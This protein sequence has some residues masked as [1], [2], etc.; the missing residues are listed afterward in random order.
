MARVVFFS[1]D[2]QRYT[3]G[4]KEAD[5]SAR[6]YRDLVAELCR[7]FPGLSEELVRKYALAIDGAII[8]TPLL[9]TIKEDSE[10]VFIP[11]IAGG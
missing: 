11:R 4:A 6:N 10:L 5:V 7:R 3:D 2:I 1:S 9:E 8:Q